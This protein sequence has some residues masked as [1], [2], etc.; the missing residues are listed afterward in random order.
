M[1]LRSAENVLSEIDTLYAS[2]IKEIIF[3]DDHFLANRERATA[4]MQGLIARKYDLTWK[5]VNMTIFLLDKEILELMR[6]S[7]SYQLTLSIESG[8]QEVLDRI[9]KKPIKLNEVHGI[10]K[11]AKSSG[12]E[13][14]TNFVFG[15]PG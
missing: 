15:F 12:F 2:G 9:I 7:G 5:C 10:I 8:C 1:R 6:D 14:I 11:A 4:I 13:V 3:L